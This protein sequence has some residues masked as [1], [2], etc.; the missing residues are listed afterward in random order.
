MSIE[1][2]RKKSKDFENRYCNSKRNGCGQHDKITKEFLKFI[3]DVSKSILDYMYECD[4]EE[5]TMEFY[6]KATSAVKLVL[7]SI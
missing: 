5:K 3:K 1:E 6:G 7:K 2:I 4:D